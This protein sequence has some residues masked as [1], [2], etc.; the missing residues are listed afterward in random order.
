MSFTNGKAELGSDVVAIPQSSFV[1]TNGTQ[2]IA[3][4][5]LPFFLAAAWLFFLATNTPVYVTEG[6]R[7]YAK[8]REYFVERYT[9]SIIGRYYF[10][11]KRWRKKVGQAAAAVPGTSFH[12][13]GLAL[14]LGSGINSSF[15]SAVHLTW[16]RIAAALGWLNTGVDFGEPW[17]QEWAIYRVKPGTKPSYPSTALASTGHASSITEE[18]DMFSDADRKMLTDLNLRTQNMR[19]DVNHLMEGGDDAKGLSTR[20]ATEILDTKITG[21]DG[22]GLTTVRQ[23]FRDARNGIFRNNKIVRAL[24]TKAGLNPDKL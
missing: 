16:T 12:G 6:Y 23:F 13:F 3:A 10:E 19:D 2:Y 20:I 11:G 14:D 15:S 4:A 5:A 18:D 24:A 9:P 8:Q 22:N 7:S 17:H 21:L 1:Q